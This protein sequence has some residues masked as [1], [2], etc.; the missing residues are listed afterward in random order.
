M[1]RC[2]T[3]HIVS[4]SM[5][6]EVAVPTPP[7]SPRGRSSGGVDVAAQTGPTSG[8]FDRAGIAVPSRRKSAP[9]RGSGGQPNANKADARAVSVGDEAGGSTCA[10]IARTSGDLGSISRPVDPLQ[11]K[12]VRCVCATTDRHATVTALLSGSG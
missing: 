5:A 3:G 11:V 12:D 6:A 7:A 4:D 2:D 9:N 8:Q 10:P 1:F